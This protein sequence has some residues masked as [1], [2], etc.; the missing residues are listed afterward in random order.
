M[1]A[2]EQGQPSTEPPYKEEKVLQTFKI[3][4]QGQ[5]PKCLPLFF[6]TNFDWIIWYKLT[7]LLPTWCLFY[8]V[9]MSLFAV[10]QRAKEI[11]CLKPGSVS[12]VPNFSLSHLVNL[13]LACLSE[14]V[15]FH[16]R[17]F[18]VHTESCEA[19]RDIWITFKSFCL[20]HLGFKPLPHGLLGFCSLGG[21]GGIWLALWPC[22]HCW[23]AI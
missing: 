21:I 8:P 9:L 14:H 13:K 3:K 7:F 4:L 6:P 12:L 17:P 22:L 2:V 1:M 15:I 18:K 5:F 20:W 19:F 16:A 10:N 11:F 23:P